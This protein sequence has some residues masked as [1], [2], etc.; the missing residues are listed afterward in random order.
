[1]K[2]IQIILNRKHDF[3]VDFS[4]D[5]KE[6]MDHANW[7]DPWRMILQGPK[8]KLEATPQRFR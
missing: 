5:S 8:R 2:W 4:P 3:W 6:A 7:G 1:M